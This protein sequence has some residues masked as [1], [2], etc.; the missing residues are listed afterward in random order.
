[1]PKLMYISTSYAFLNH[2]RKVARTL[3]PKKELKSAK[4]QKDTEEETCQCL[5]SAEP[6]G[7]SRPGEKGVSCTD[8]DK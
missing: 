2:R 1:M 7:N 8:S 3:V 4:R 6:F 5:V